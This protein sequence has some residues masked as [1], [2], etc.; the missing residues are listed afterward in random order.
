MANETLF[1]SS[2]VFGLINLFLFLIYEYYEIINSKNKYMIELRIL[3]IISIIIIIT[4]IYNHGYTNN[5]YKWID[6]IIVYIGIIFSIY[7]AVKCKIFISLILIIT[8]IIC[9]Y[10]TKKMNIN[11]YHIFIYT[12]ITL[13]N[14]IL[15]SSGILHTT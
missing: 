9:Y 15:L 4:S 3:Q 11:T 5:F 2:I 7:L 8:V 6:R 1:Y 12:L 10:L 14:Y 13:N